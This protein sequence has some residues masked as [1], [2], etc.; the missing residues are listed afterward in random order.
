MATQRVICI[1]NLH[2]M[3]HSFIKG[4]RYTVTTEFPENGDVNVNFYLDGKIKTLKWD[5][6]FIAPF[7]WLVVC[8]PKAWTALTDNNESLLS[9]NELQLKAAMLDIASALKL[10][11]EKCTASD[12]INLMRGNYE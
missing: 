6:G 3:G 10:D 8:K 4:D 2:C 11:G 9:M 5:V 12:I 7:K 1:R